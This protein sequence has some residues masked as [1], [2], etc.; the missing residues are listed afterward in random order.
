VHAIGGAG[1]SVVDIMLR[2]RREEAVGDA[3]R[4]PR[5]SRKL[6]QQGVPPVAPRRPQEG[7]EA[8]QVPR[9]SEVVLIDRRVDLFS[10]LCSQF[11][12]QALIDMLY[13]VEKNQTNIGSAEWAKER[14]PIVRLSP[15]DPFYQEIRDLHIDK[16][17]PLLQEKARAIQKTYSEKDI[18]RN[19]SEMAEYIKKFKTAHSAHPL[20][21]IHINLAHDLRD[22]IQSEDYRADLRLE[23]EITAQSSQSSLETI[24][25][26]IDDQKPLHEVLRLL[27]LYSLV[28]NGVKPKQL[29]QLKRGIVQSYGY[30]HLLTLC[31]LEKVGMLRYH[32]GKS[33]WSE[34]KRKFNLL[35]EDSLAEGDISY[36]YSGYAPLSVRLV[37]LTRSLPKGWRSCQDALS[38]L[39]GPAQELQQPLEGGNGNT[40]ETPQETGQSSVVLVVFLGGV[41]HGEVA[42]LRRLAE[43]EEGRRQFLVMTTEFMGVRR[44]FDSMRCAQVFDQPPPEPWKA[45]PQEQ[46]RRGFGFWPGAR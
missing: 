23:D 35:V 13:G 37:Q 30:K 19:P 8:S 3:Q 6:S 31:N 9:I 43:L 10:L 28:N 26:F 20:L 18:V 27:C 46:Q 7:A 25:N 11:T 38:L 34:I 29:D 39:Y 33:G 21:E 17:G 16:L 22:A 32:Q 44:L 14:S 40:A 41:T 15:E 24:E 12:Y 2:L 36:A 4:E 45:Q 42:A 1:K 5:A